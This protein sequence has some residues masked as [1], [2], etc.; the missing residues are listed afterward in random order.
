[1]SWVELL[2][3]AAT[4]SV[5]AMFCMRTMIP[6]RMMALASN[7]LFSLYGYLDGLYPVMIAH[8]VLFPVNLVRLIEVR[9]LIEELDSVRPSDLSMQSW[10]IQPRSTAGLAHSP[11]KPYNIPFLG[12]GPA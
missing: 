9:R 6:L 5:L 4:A 1:M 8:L 3:Y 7:V 11:R 12:R 10:L 2:G